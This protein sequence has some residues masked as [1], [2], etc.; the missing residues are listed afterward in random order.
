M[1]LPLIVGVD[2]SDSSLV[3]LDRATDEAV[4]HGT[5]GERVQRR[6][7]EVKA[8]ADV[9]AEDAAVEVL[10][11]AGHDACALLTGSR[12]RGGLKG[13]LL[14]SVG[15]TVAARVVGHRL[16]ERLLGPRTGPVTQGAVQH[17]D[18]P[19]TVGRTPEDSA[20]RE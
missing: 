10:L 6:R 14:G 4:R 20:A 17:L 13:L 15:L 19:V 5:A 8:S 12:G 16:A 3:A 11:R 2:G 1:E 18:C 9:V 7:P